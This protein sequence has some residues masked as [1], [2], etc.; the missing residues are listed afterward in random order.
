MASPIDGIEAIESLPETSE[1]EKNDESTQ[2]LPEASVIPEPDPTP[3][4]QGGSNEEAPP[5]VCADL[6]ELEPVEVPGSQNEAVDDT[7]TFEPDNGEVLIV[8]EAE[9]V[10]SGPPPET[11]RDPSE[12]PPV[13]ESTM[14]PEIIDDAQ[15]DDH[16]DERRV[17]FAPGTP[18]PKPTPRKKKAAKG[19][20]NKKKRIAVPLDEVPADILAMIDDNFDGILLPPPPPPP[21]APEIPGE[22]DNLPPADVAEIQPIEGEQNEPLPDGDSSSDPVQADEPKSQLEPSAEGIVDES[23]LPEGQE[24]DDLPPLDLLPPNDLGDKSVPPDETQAEEPSQDPIDTGDVTAVSDPPQLDP[25]FTSSVPPDGA[26]PEKPAKKKSS[27]SSKDKSKKKSSKSRS[28][29][30]S[31]P[32]PL[33]GLGIDVGPPPVSDIDDLTKDIP[34]VLEDV[35]AQSPGG[36]PD[37]PPPSSETEALG[38]DVKE[39]P[40]EDSVPAPS[41]PVVPDAP[42]ETTEE[43]Q[44]VEDSP[45]EQ[46]DDVEDN[47]QAPEQSD[48]AKLGVETPEPTCEEAEGQDQPKAELV[49]SPTDSG[50]AFEDAEKASPDGG[51]EVSSPVVE[52]LEVEKVDLPNG[53]EEADVSKDG[54]TSATDVEPSTED[55]P[56]AAP[57]ATPKGESQPSED[58]STTESEPVTVEEGGEQSSSGEAGGSEPAAESKEDTA[59]QDAPAESAV[60]ESAEIDSG[61][62]EVAPAEEGDSSPPDEPQSEPKVKGDEVQPEEPAPE[63]VSEVKLDDVQP[64]EPQ[65][66]AK[67]EDAEPQLPQPDPPAEEVEPEA[68]KST[69]EVIVDDAAVL[70]TPVPEEKTMTDDGPGPEAPPS[71]NLSKTSSSGSRESK[72]ARWER[73]HKENALKDVF[74]DS[75]RVLARSKGGKEEIVRVKGRSQK[76]RRLSSAEEDEARRRRRALR[77]A[78]EA[79]RLV[80]EEKRKLEEEKE[81]RTRREERR[82]ARKAEAEVEEKIKRLREEADMIR[83]SRGED[84]AR[85]KRHRDRDRNREPAA[86]HRETKDAGPLLKLPS[87]PKVL[88][89]TNGE[90]YTGSRPNRQSRELQ[91]AGP[92]KN[93]EEAIPREPPQETP[94]EESTRPSSSSGSKSHH[95]HRHH[96]RTESDRPSRSRRDSDHRPL[97]P[98]VEERSKSFLGSLLR[99]S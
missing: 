36:D 89:L 68:P 77:K 82:A 58:Q 35:P 73:K 57:E 97:R 21:P 10:Q 1:K 84:E 71:P 7:K 28:K 48:D 66:E 47:G 78:E 45:P 81:R 60:E 2:L 80:E 19:T 63:P 92:S 64:E 67:V 65:P 46:T 91:T 23:T 9:V 24:S 94:K 85:R 90:S 13:S 86:P 96:H 42:L 5:P 34:P 54:E 79:A 29:E 22:S 83:A 72:N 14:E 44:V 38:E 51:E 52:S 61:G 30:S 27:K 6:P 3:D 18:E 53:D 75:S 39:T 31:P 87:L 50:I 62:Q 95:R 99:R 69:D 70:D 43:T 15:S 33:A 20:K 16:V 12:L 4:A 93:R 55:A 49:S 76:S 88:G 26:E 74:E 25:I 32:P 56:E 17:S 11:M 8:D 41:E 37:A 98:V 40:N 59:V